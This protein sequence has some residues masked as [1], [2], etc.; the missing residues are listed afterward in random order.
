MGDNA[1]IKHYDFR[2]P[3]ENLTFFATSGSKNATATQLLKSRWLMRASSIASETHPSS[4]KRYDEPVAVRW[5]QTAGTPEWFIWRR[6]RYPVD[7]VMT[8]WI[9]DRYWWDEA[10]RESRSCWRV[11]SGTGIYELYFDRIGRC[12]R[13]E[14][15]LD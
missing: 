2:P 7:E 8:V 12:W 11:R 13:L 15:V 1:A 3:G 6:A 5:D 10:K 14:S 4:G 9:I